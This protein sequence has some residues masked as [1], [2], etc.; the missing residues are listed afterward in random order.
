MIKKIAL[1]ILIIIILFTGVT[2]FF[3]QPKDISLKDI[4]VTDSNYYLVK[5]YSKTNNRFDFVRVYRICNSNNNVNYQYLLKTI[6]INF[7]ICEDSDN[8]EELEYFNND[9]DELEIYS[10]SVHYKLLGVQSTDF[11]YFVINKKSQDCYIVQLR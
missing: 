2:V 5:E 8:I 3:S 11:Y 4:G 1:I 6:N 7:S 10:S 9:I